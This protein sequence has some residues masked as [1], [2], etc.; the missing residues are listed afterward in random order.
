MNCIRGWE[1]GTS[2]SC[3]RF[4]VHIPILSTR[5]FSFDGIASHKVLGL[6]SHVTVSLQHCRPR[7]L[8]FLAILLGFEASEWP[9]AAVP[10]AAAKQT[11]VDNEPPN[12]KTNHPHPSPL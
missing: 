5:I 3:H 10:A 2:D 4:W 9:D 12:I 6:T 11:L 8:M 7:V 1:R